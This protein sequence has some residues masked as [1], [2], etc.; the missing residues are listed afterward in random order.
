LGHAGG[1]FLLKKSVV[2]MIG[3]SFAFALVGCSMGDKPSEQIYNHL[4]EAAVLEE[5]FETQQ[6]PLVEAEKKEQQLY[7]EIISL[8]MKKIEKIISLSKEA[9]ASAEERKKLIKEE[10]KSLEKAYKEFAEIESVIDDIEETELKK[11]AEDI[12]KTMEQRYT[13][14]QELYNSYTKS[15]ELDIELY[16]MLQNKELTP[17]DLQK[18]IDEINESYE[19]INEKKEDFNKL[20]EQ[21]NAFKKEFY[22]VAGIELEEA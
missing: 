2:A 7:E 9:T 8:S 20:T 11:K 16:K 6:H 19:T 17:E 4:E 18:Q 15:T 5:G 12:Y 14:Y 3:F 1:I 22:I 21:Y 13:V 10:K